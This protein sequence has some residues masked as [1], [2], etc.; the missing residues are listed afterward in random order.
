MTNVEL[1][2]PAGIRTSFVQQLRL[3]GWSGR[4]AFLVLGLLGLLV[5]AGTMRADAHLGLPR[6]VVAAMFGLPAPVLWALFVWHGE[7]PQRRSYHWSLPVPRPGHDLARIAAGAVWLLA[8]YLALAAVGAI[9]A[10]TSGDWAHFASIG[11]AWAT[12]FVGPL[13]LYLLT[14]PLALWSDSPTLRRSMVAFI[15]VAIVA[16]I[17]Q[18]EVYRHVA[19]AVFGRGWGL[20]TALIGGFLRQA[21]VETGAPGVLI[22]AAL[23]LGIGLTATVFAATW[24]PADLARLARRRG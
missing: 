2:T 15:G 16:A 9:V 17:L 24:R 3:L 1:R 21:G 22:V 11:P 19:E 7:L 5:A 23:W 10:A 4:W 20:T 12:F 8:A 13:V 14:S 18:L 6:M